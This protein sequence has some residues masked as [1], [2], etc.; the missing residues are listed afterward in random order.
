MRVWHG[1][2]VCVKI[3]RHTKGNVAVDIGKTLSKSAALMH[4]AAFLCLAAVALLSPW[5]FGSWEMWWFWPVAAMIF[6]GAFFAGSSTLLRS[7][8]PTHLRSEGAASQ[9]LRSDNRMIFLLAFVLPFL[10]YAAWRMGKPLA[11]ELPIVRMEAERSLML[12]ATPV[13]LVFSLF[14]IGTRPRVKLLFL[15]LI[16]NATVI[17][18][19]AIANHLING[20]TLILWAPSFKY[21]GRASLPFFCPNHLAAYLNIALCGLIAIWLSPRSGRVLRFLLLLPA[22]PMLIAWFMTLSR[23]GTA[24]LLLGALPVA[25]TIGLRGHNLRLRLLVPVIAVAIAIGSAWALIKVENPMRERFESNVLTGYLIKAEKPEWETAKKIFMTKFDRGTYIGSAIRAW[26][27]SPRIGIGPG[28]HAI[29]WPQFA[30]SDD[31]DRET[32]R[33]PSL[34]NH[35]YYL[36]EVHSDWTQLLEEYGIFGLLLFLFGTVGITASLYR[37]QSLA[38]EEAALG[39]SGPFE[40]SLP[41]AALLALAVF[42]VHSLGDFSLQIP[43]VTWSLAILVGCGLL[44]TLPLR[45]PDA[46]DANQ[47][48]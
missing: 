27:T 13:L 46:V 6:A 26:R 17:A 40:R 18:V 10:L 36:Y 15:I 16:A 37:A 38:V 41:L 12:F 14:L 28:Q 44:S 20:S 2:A 31:G 45:N 39:Q 23:G 8:V 29:R 34:T 19:A 43:A 33:W 30:A 7:F 35:T 11:P 21:R 1:A 48:S 9:R 24:S 3:R 4:G 42:A 22:V 32:A 47:E 25:L 5:A